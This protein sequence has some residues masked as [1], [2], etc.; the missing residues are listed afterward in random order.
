MEQLSAAEATALR[1]TLLEALS[2]RAAAELL[3]VSAMS[4]QRAQ[5]KAIASLRQRLEG[6]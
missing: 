6:S 2:L 1:L 5:K 4:A 3:E